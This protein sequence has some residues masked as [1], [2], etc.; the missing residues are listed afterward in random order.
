MAIR[1][2]AMDIIASHQ[3]GLV[4][5]LQAEAIGLAGFRRDSVQR[6]I[7]CHHVA[8]MLGASHGYALLAAS[9]GLEIDPA[10]TRMEAVARR[11]RW[12][13]SASER[14]ALGERVVAFADTVRALDAE[15]C[16]AL[17]M[18]YRLVAT[19]GLSGHAERRL[20]ADLL[21]ALKD[22]LA[23]RD[24]SDADS[25]RALFVAHHVWAESQFGQRVTD[26][27]AQ[28]EWPASAAPLRTVVDALRIPLASFERAERRG[29]ERLERQ[30]RNSRLFPPGFAANPAQAFFT[31]Q[32]QLA[33]RRRASAADDH[34]PVDEAVSLAA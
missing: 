26:A 10:L 21:A 8:D 34:W 18:A 14:A 17:L 31:L 32:R 12:G 27:V 23:R 28:L 16:A 11:W 13:S 6:A 15:R 4:E 9:G 30:L 29:L 20:D 2:D 24:K 3:S 25:R 33:E 5:Q 19:P 22:A 1:H 7:V